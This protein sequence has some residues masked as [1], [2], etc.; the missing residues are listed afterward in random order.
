MSHL[1]LAP[2]RSDA[3]DDRANTANRRRPPTVMVHA[4]TATGLTESGRKLAAVPVVPQ[5]T[6]AITR[7]TTL[8]GRV[9]KVVLTFP[10]LPALV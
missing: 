3:T 9:A 2:L 5:S 8:A 6:D 1:R 10:R 7:A 4:P